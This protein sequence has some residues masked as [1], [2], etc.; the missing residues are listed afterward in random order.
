MVPTLVEFD[1]EGR[2]GPFVLDLGCSCN[3]VSNWLELSNRS[4]ILLDVSAH[5]HELATL[6]DAP[7]TIECDLCEFERTTA[8]FKT[9]EEIFRKTGA[10]KLDAIIAAD[11][12]INY[13]PWCT[14]FTVLDSY[15]QKEGF[16]FLCFGINIGRGEAFH[17]ERPNSPLQVIEFFTKNLGY[18]LVEHGSQKDCH[19]LVYK[20]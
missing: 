15:L 12:L 10:K 7:I 8:D 9:F 1:R 14:V 2:I 5:V 16:V 13:I 18:T 19:G 17:I 4:R 11:N 20:K 6:P 3:P